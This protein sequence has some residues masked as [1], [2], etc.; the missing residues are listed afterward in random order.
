LGVDADAPDGPLLARF[1]G[2]RDEAAFATLVR[3]HGPLVWGVCRRVLGDGP[4]AEDCFQATF[5]V[6]VRRAGSVARPDLL[7]NWL[8][9]VAYRTALQ[10]RA[11][12]ARRRDRE[13]RMI[14]TPATDPA[15]EVD[16]R[17]L[18]QFLDAEL[19]RL[20]ER[21]RVPLVLCYL[22]GQTQEEVARLLGCPRKTVTTRLARACERLRGRLAR[23]GLALSAGAVAAG[24]L[25]E[26]ASAAVAA[27]VADAAVRVGVAYAA[28]GV[29]PG[30]AVALT[31]GVLQAMWVNK[32][33]M[34][35]M[36]LVAAAGVTVAV[37]GTAY[38][39]L[40]DKPPAAAKA[41]KKVAAKETDAEKLQ[42]TWKAISFENAGKPAAENVVKDFRLVIG[43]N[44]FTF[45]PTGNKN[46][47]TFT[48][49][50]SKEPKEITLTPLQGPMKGRPVTGI[51]RL[52]GDTLTLCVCN[53]SDKPG[54]KPD[55]FKTEKGDGR[56]LIVLK[57]I[58]R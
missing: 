16:Q 20:P 30:R 11:D 14:S 43:E 27:R 6:L 58:S 49:D 41:D 50:P 12:A 36:W 2:Q 44:K 42:G 9:G 47:S 24:L 32:M 28:A 26:A 56:G 13:A 15:D 51:Y 29:V 38:R 35:A 19:S 1:A 7:G 37:S 8:Y 10:A 39:A 5:L 48:V 3:R 22:E 17:D 52:E 45:S 55:A 46:Q 57:R 33:R 53:V 34:A 25:H 31:E 18:R 4:D 23:R 40:A 21:Y 54:D